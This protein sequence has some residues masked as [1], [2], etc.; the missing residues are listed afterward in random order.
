MKKRMTIRHISMSDLPVLTGYNNEMAH[1][2]IKKLSHENTKE[3]KSYS[4]C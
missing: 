1:K 4:S 3:Y 2:S